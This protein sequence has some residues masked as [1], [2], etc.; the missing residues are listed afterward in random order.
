MDNLV[1]APIEQRKRSHIRDIYGLYLLLWLG[2]F[3]GYTC[4]T[5]SWNAP[6]EPWWMALVIVFG[7]S[8]AFWA[9]Y[10]LYRFLRRHTVDPMFCGY[11]RA[12]PEVVTM[13]PDRS[14][15]FQCVH[16][17]AVNVK[18]GPGQEETTMT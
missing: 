17:E 13:T 3:V 12:M 5:D 10:G 9:V 4:I 11:C 6:I 14:L 15:Y 18:P 16:C 8:V 7:K 2:G 1:V